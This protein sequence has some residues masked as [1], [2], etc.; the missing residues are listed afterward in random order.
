VS[1]ATPPKTAPPGTAPPGTAPPGTAPPGTAPPGAAP[2]GAGGLSLRWRIV[3]A[4]TAIPTVVVLLTGLLLAAAGVG[5]AGSAVGSALVTLVASVLVGVPV[6]FRLTYRLSVVAGLARRVNSG[7]LEVSRRA[8]PGSLGT[9]EV[10]DIYRALDTLATRARAA[11]HSEVRFTADVAHEL[12][13]PLTGLVTAAELLPPGRPSELVQDRV[14]KLR[15]LVEDLLEVSRLD[16]RVETADLKPCDLG[17]LVKQIVTN[18]MPE[19]RVDVVGDARVLTDP[20]RVDR[21]LTNLLNNARR[22][23]A[24]PYEVTVRGPVVTVRDHGPGFPEALIAHGP[25]RFRTAR[26]E[27]GQGHGL[28]LTIAVG[29]AGVVG[30]DLHFANHPDGGA[31][32]TLDLTARRVD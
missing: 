28:G 17:P 4:I 32:I 21:V 13:T 25:R 9:D 16:S 31:I 1:D 24:P 5:G 29:Q 3:L 18:A 19:A 10:S 20:R 2:E 14:R 22:H 7:A 11:G 23:G 30:T 12:R 6:A 26:R 8:M 27:R 15:T